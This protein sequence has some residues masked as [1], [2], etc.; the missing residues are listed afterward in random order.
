MKKIIILVFIFTIILSVSAS[1]ESFEDWLNANEDGIVSEN[2]FQSFINA[3][4]KIDL[5]RN[6]D[7]ENVNPSFKLNLHDFNNQF[8]DAPFDLFN[9]NEIDRYY[10]HSVKVKDFL[11]NLINAFLWTSTLFIITR[12][13]GG[14][15]S[16]GS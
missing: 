9:F 7:Y 10:Y 14:V 13:L 1:A 11:W 15:Q 12:K 8:P 2:L 3:K 16:D 6:N 5:L 4:R